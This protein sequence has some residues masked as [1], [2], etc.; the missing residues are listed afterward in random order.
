MLAAL[1]S[2]SCALAVQPLVPARA[3]APA[4][5]HVHAA[6]PAAV[7]TGALV[8]NT[9]SAGLN[10]VFYLSPLRVTVMR[11]LF[12]LDGSDFL[13]PTVGAFM[14][15]GGLQA[16]LAIHCFLALLGLR[17]PAETLINMAITH[18]IQSAIGLWRTVANKEAGV[19][20][21]SA[22]AGAG[23]GPTVAAAVLCAA[24]CAGALLVS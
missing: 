2:T 12:G 8:L 3:H 22:L 24:S 20:T 9:A 23:G 4:R 1:L 16:A 10:G 15:L 7:T 19:S 17:S 11:S 5:A 14:F 21:L 18:A 13:S 6:M